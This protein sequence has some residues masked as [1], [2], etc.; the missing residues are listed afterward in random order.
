MEAA[1]TRGLRQACQPPGDGRNRRPST[2]H[3]S[4]QAVVRGGGKYALKS[5]YE[6]GVPVPGWKP[7]IGKGQRK[8]NPDRW[9]AAVAQLQ[10]EGVDA[11][12]ITRTM[13]ETLGTLK[14][15]LGAERMARL[16]RMMA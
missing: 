6:D 4:Y 14:K 1:L 5:A 2:P 11:M 9:L 10:E 16:E 7:V 15:V 12:R 8:I 13:P 3:P